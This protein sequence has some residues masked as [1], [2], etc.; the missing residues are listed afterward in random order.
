MDEYRDFLFLPLTHTDGQRHIISKRKYINAY[1][2][3]CGSVANLN[4]LHRRIDDIELA[5]GRYRKR[6]C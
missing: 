4:E 3:L 1:E 6:E 2:C 5:A